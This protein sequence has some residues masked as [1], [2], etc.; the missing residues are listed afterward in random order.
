MSAGQRSLKRI[1]I[2]HA[3]GKALFLGVL[4]ILGSSIQI[5]QVRASGA[6]VHA[7]EVMGDVLEADGRFAEE[8]DTAPDCHASGVCV[9]LALSAM[10]TPVPPVSASTLFVHRPPLKPIGRLEGYFRPPRLPQHI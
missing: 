6:H 8:K 2:A 7:T 9:Y 3:W 5:E 1:R 4:I 10:P